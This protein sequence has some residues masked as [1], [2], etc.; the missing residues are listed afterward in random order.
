[1]PRWLDQWST[2]FWRIMPRLSG[3]YRIIA[4]GLGDRVSHHLGVASLHLARFFFLS[5]FSAERSPLSSLTI[6]RFFPG[7]AGPSGF[8]GRKKIASKHVLVRS[9]LLPFDK[10]VLLTS[11]FLGY[12]AK[13]TFGFGQTYDFVPSAGLYLLAKEF[14]PPLRHSTS[15][16]RWKYRTGDLSVGPAAFPEVHQD[17]IF[18]SAPSGGRGHCRRDGITQCCLTICFA[19]RAIQSV[20]LCGRQP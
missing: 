10:L 9:A 20:V 11:S 19:A 4:T 15:G 2:G 14:P 8:V 17:P 18:V 1:M 7:T 6:F 3:K 16:S 13:L 5:S 12:L